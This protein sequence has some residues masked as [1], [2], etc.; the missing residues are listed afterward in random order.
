MTQFPDGRAVTHVPDA[1]VVAAYRHLQ[2]DAERV[3]RGWAAPDEAQECLRRDYLAHLAAYPDAMAKAGPPAHLTAS[4]LVLDAARERVLLTL[5]GKA[6]R[7][8][9]L[10]GHLES[11]D[12]G[13]SAAALREG[14]EEGGI[15][16]LELLPGPVQLD[17]HELV[18]AFGRC[19]EHLDV[20]YAAVAPADATEAMSEESLDLRWWPV[21]ELPE[22][23]DSE[24]G[25]L[26][27]A[28]L[29]A[30]S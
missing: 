28:A 17:R 10:G 20:R 18:G 21:D 6:R 30:A 7:W 11:T 16:A 8:F 24:I 4:L 9:Q 5:H 12:A 29:A 19:R 22:G 2:E 23:P 1:E 27:R 13:L 25:A 15:T 3:L 14:V 26:V